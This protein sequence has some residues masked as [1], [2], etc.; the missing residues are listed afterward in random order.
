MTCLRFNYNKHA[1]NILY[2]NVLILLLMTSLGS[3][4]LFGYGEIKDTYG[5]TVFIKNGTKDTIFLKTSSDSTKIDINDIYNDKLLPDSIVNI[6]DVSPEDPNSDPIQEYLDA[7]NI[8]AYVVHKDGVILKKWL[9]DRAKTGHS[10]Y[11]PE[12]WEINRTTDPDVSGWIKFSIEES[13]LEK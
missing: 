13:D 7:Y 4:I 2:R 9:K 6:A 11:N 10:P 5:Y 12:S 3:C 8:E 1:R